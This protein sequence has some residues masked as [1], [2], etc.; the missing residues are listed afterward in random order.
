MIRQILA[1]SQVPR[2]E[3][4]EDVIVRAVL[5]AARSVDPNVQA[6]DDPDIREY[7]KVK[8]IPGGMPTDT[9][10]VQGIVISKGVVHK[11]MVRRIVRPRILLIDFPLEYER[12]ENQFV[13]LERVLSQEREHLGN[14]VARITAVRP[15]VLVATKTVSRL[16]SEL[17]QSTGIA[18]SS[19]VR[20][21][22][23]ETI[24]RSTQADIAHSI[25]RLAL[26]LRLGSCAAF[27]VRYYHDADR[28][29]KSFLWF[30]GCLPQLGATIVLRGGELDRLTT[31]KQAVSLALLAVHSMKL[32]KALVIDQLATLYYDDQEA[33]EPT[34]NCAFPPQ[35]N[36]TDAGA[37]SRY[38]VYRDAILSWS[39]N[40][41]IPAP[42]TVVKAYREALVRLDGLP[43]S[44]NLD[45]TS[46][47]LVMRDADF[48]LSDTNVL[49]PF[50]HQ[51]IIVLSYLLAAGNN[52]PCEH[53]EFAEIDYYGSSDITLGQFA[54]L[55]CSQAMQ[56]C[57]AKGCG[58]PF[59]LHSR[60][61]VHQRCQ[62]TISVE[63]MPCP[64]SGMENRFL[65]WSTCRICGKSTPYTAMS[66]DT[67]RLSVGKYLEL[68]FYLGQMACRAAIC[69]HDPFREHIRWIGHGKMA[70]R[71]EYAP[72]TLLDVLP[73]PRKTAFRHDIQARLKDQ[74]AMHVRAIITRFFDQ[75]AD[76]L[77]RI[78][79]VDVVAESAQGQELCR[80][81]LASLQER[82]QVEKARLLAA[83]DNAL[84]SSPDGDFTTLNELYGTFFKTHRQWENDFANFGRTYFQLEAKDLRRIT[85]AQF[86]R[87]FVEDAEKNH[88]TT[89]ELS[90]S[91]FGRSA[92]DAVPKSTTVETSPANVLSA[93]SIS[94]D[95]SNGPSL[96]SSLG[97]PALEPSSFPFP[98]SIATMPFES[99]PLVPTRAPK[100]EESPVDSLP[101]ASG[102]EGGTE[103]L[104]EKQPQPSIM[105]TVATIWNGF[106]Y[107]WAPLESVLSAS[108]H[109]LPDSPVVIREDEPSSLIAYSLSTRD[110]ANK[111]EELKGALSGEGLGQGQPLVDLGP[112][113][114]S[115][116]DEHLSPDGLNALEELL[117]KDSGHNMKIEMAESSTNMFCKIFYVEQFD[118]LREACGLDPS[119][120]VAS[121]ARCVKWES[122]GGKSGSTFLKT[123]DERF[124]MKELSKPEM[125]SFLQLA[126]QY[127]RYISQAL[128]HRLPTAIAKIF[129]L[130]HIGFK[131]ASGKT[132]KLDVVVME[133]LWYGR[134]VSRVYDLKG[135]LRN[136]LATATGKENEVLLDEN[137]REVM[138]KEPFYLRESD[139]ALLRASLQ[140]DTLFF[141][142]A[143]IMD[144]S[145]IVGVDSSSSELVVGIV[146]YIRTFTW[147]KKLESWAKEA[148]ILGRGKEPT[149]VGP[150]QYRS[151]FREA[152]DR[153]FLAVPDKW[154]ARLGEPGKRRGL[155]G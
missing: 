80:T 44:K 149:I 14:L 5:E 53:P 111:L 64:I 32:E 66:D 123:A 109:I 139:K 35:F 46:M 49:S 138:Y 132:V 19:G 13:S 108:E 146:D 106:A 42:H 117:L 56:L 52:V 116:E 102:L 61:L 103:E 150:R 29:R 55:L 113:A 90:P 16:A 15:D 152:M 127:F 41:S 126:P 133:N 21:G 135:S 79:L 37:I 137:L 45:D 9:E 27:D 69:R 7:V 30:E 72:I 18:V 97:S 140:N 25:D 28:G 48:R 98:G 62:I 51:N 125:E 136:R 20:P 33:V 40:V 144:Y 38:R 145:L 58:K 47:S 118:A 63:R 104:R 31:I 99:P 81:E 77:S 130:Y 85:A 39:P 107:G 105:K 128:F 59:L 94:R 65:M 75:I 10:F 91:T 143:N 73:P 131:N 43:S 120:F 134:K 76:R 96:G 142:K 147:D 95:G 122:A 23:V 71:I 74:E 67:W 124:I 87:V 101:D 114:G 129:G 60:K 119:L 8:R 151:R 78:S 153:Y 83:L 54:E 50:G 88:L 36:V 70:V 2:E 22:V 100:E 121:L 154:T 89:S 4:W 112:K 12:V 92:L 141:S 34:D 1:E 57:H 3:G 110:Y 24:A 84:V 148:G 17:L 86:R 11:S 93:S 82:A 155:L 6:G 26:N 68:T 115:T